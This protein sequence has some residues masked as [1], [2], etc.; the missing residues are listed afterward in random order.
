VQQAETLNMN[1]ALISRGALDAVGFLSD[2]FVHS[3][4]DFEY[5]LKLR[6]EGGQVLLAP[7]HIGRCAMNPVSLTN[8]TDAPDLLAALKMLR[9]PKRE[10][11]GQRFR[12]YR[13]HGGWLWPLFFVSP[14]ITIWLHPL[15]RWISGHQRND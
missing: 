4:A 13:S 2:Y 6:K 14:Y 12:M 1:G 3:N 10:P 9:D 15:R 11:V 8:P 7:R 5:G